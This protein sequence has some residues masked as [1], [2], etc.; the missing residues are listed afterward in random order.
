MDLD[1]FD[2]DLDPDLDTDLGSRMGLRRDA[3]S[4]RAI[5]RRIATLTNSPGCSP[6]A[7]RADR[8]AVPAEM[9][10]VRCDA[11]SS[12]AS[13][14]WARPSRALRKVARRAVDQD[15]PEPA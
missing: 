6:A 15:E 3:A 8:P 12:P 1:A 13:T 10:R 11:W 14:S 9:R 4:A 2:L 5:R 7:R